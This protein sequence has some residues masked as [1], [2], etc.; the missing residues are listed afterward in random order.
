MS[1]FAG[2][3]LGSKDCKV[4]HIVVKDGDTVEQVSP[5]VFWTVYEIGGGK[6]L[7]TPVSKFDFDRQTFIVPSQLL[8]AYDDRSRSIIRKTSNGTS[9]SPFGG[10]I[11]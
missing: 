4:K 1:C 8:R 6:R 7:L 5:V 10:I 3:E 11:V 9:V 2:L